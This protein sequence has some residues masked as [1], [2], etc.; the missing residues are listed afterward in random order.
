MIRYVKN[1]GNFNFDHGGPQSHSKPALLL[2]REINCGGRYI[3]NISILTIS[4][5]EPRF[6]RNT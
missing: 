5:T 6:C 1:K 4:I 3:D 2:K